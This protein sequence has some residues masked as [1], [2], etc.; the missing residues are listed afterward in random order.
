MP[1]MGV[2][3]FSDTPPDTRCTCGPSRL[4][5]LEH[6]A[7]RPIAHHVLDAM[8]AAGVEEVIVAGT[9]D[10]LIDVRA[11]LNRYESSALGVE[12]A[13]SGAHADPVTILRAASQLVGAAPCI[14][15]VG[16]GLL[17][18]PLTQYVEALNEHSLDLVLLCDG[19]SF[20]D[21]P[22]A[23]L[24]HRESTVQG[25]LCEAG[26]GMF[27]PGAF[28]DAC[29][30]TR[31]PAPRVWRRSH[32]ASLTMAATCASAWPRAGAA[33]AVTRATSSRST[34]WP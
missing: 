14:V 33:I 18:T 5:A 11:C 30:R 12:Y 10:A 31:E 23:T 21:S 1:Q 7:N 3:V 13:P 15:H 8:V 29:G 24:D 22:S 25:I 32:N 20:A 19:A 16:D 27:G 9:A 6:V 2:L 34:G 28:R 26:V 4:P 17:D